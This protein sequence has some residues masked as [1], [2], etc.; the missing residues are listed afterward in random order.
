MKSYMPKVT[1]N[2]YFIVDADSFGPQYKSTE[3]LEKNELKITSLSTSSC[4]M[5][6]SCIYLKYDATSICEHLGIYPAVWSD[7]AFGEGIPCRYKKETE[8]LDAKTL[9]VEGCPGGKDSCIGCNKL[10]SVEVRSYPHKS[11]SH[12]ICG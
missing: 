10:L 3:N 11:H 6:T 5:N 4:P 12:V 1:G 7:K 9:R 8:V 2:R